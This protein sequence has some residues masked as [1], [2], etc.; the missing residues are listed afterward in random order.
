[1][2]P[3]KD[4]QNSSG[5][6]KLLQL[7]A[8]CLSICTKAALCITASLWNAGVPP[9]HRLLSLYNSSLLNILVFVVRK[10]WLGDNKNLIMVKTPL[11]F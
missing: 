2:F 3:S 5:E 11:R 8:E 9:R 10:W 1:M 7:N 4:V 6:V